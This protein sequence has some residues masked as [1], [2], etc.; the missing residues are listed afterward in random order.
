MADSN[1][2]RVDCVCVYC[3]TSFTLPRCRLS[4]GMG[5][6]CKACR[7]VTDSER[8]WRR[9][10][11]SGA[12]WLWLGSRHRQ[13]HG[14]AS[15][16]GRVQY[17]HRVSWQL[18]HG[19]IPEGHVVCHKCDN[20]PCVNPDHLF[21]GTQGDNVR[22]ARAKGRMTTETMR[23]AKLSTENVLTVR[24]MLASGTTQSAV[25]A[26]MGVTRSCIGLIAQGRRWTRTRREA[27]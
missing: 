16:N 6:T 2:K 21:V 20:P 3:G 7:S 8:F 12:C 11:R 23:S 19:P 17:A 9:V 18:T 27:E 25:A 14:Y 15:L 1:S 26:A 22:D 4:I 13:G 24:D 5:K 10:D